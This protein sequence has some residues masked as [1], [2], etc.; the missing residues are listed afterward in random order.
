[1]VGGNLAEGPEG[2]V[3]SGCDKRIF[4]T[5]GT[6]TAPKKKQKK[7]SRVLG[8]KPNDRGGHNKKRRGEIQ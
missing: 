3:I 8:R 7:R 4:Q 1:M 5:N 6:K 2:A